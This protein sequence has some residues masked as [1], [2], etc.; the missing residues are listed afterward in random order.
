MFEEVPVPSMVLGPRT[1][2]YVLYRVMHAREFGGQNAFKSC[3]WSSDCYLILVSSRRKVLVRLI[4]HPTL[5]IAMVLVLPLPLAM[6]DHH[7]G[8]PARRRAPHALKDHDLGLPTCWHPPL[9]LLGDAEPPSRS[10]VL[11]FILS[12]ALSD[13]RR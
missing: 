10:V 9:A 6:Q 4:E 11:C 1:A 2:S 5:C 13:V 3:R 7:L 12:D 8:P